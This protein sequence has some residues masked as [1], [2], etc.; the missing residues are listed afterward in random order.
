MEICED[1][2]SSNH[3]FSGGGRCRASP[4]N[5]DHR[6]AAALGKPATISDAEVSLRKKRVM[7]MKND[8][9]N[10]SLDT[11]AYQGSYCGG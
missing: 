2:A 6:A 5:R 4:L 8:L 11:L 1:G 3:R 9:A 10:R 7:T